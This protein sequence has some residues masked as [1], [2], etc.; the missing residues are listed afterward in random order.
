MGERWS[1][2]ARS[3]AYLL[4]ARLVSETAWLL[5]GGVDPHRDLPRWLPHEAF[6]ALAALFLTWVF[7]RTEGRGLSSI[8]LGWSLAWWGLFLRGLLTGALIIL[9]SALAAT[10]G[11]VRWSLGGLD[12]GGFLAGA[13]LYLAV[14]LLEELQFRGYPFQRLVQGLGSWPGQLLFAAYF[15][16]AHW[17]NPGM[18]GSTR[19]WATLNIGLAALLF[20]YSWLRSG[21]L[22]PAL[23]MHFAWNLVQG[24]LL[25]FGVSGTAGLGF[26]QP[27]A[28]EGKAWMHGGSFGLEAALPCALACVLAFWIL[29]RALPPARMESREEP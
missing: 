2:I 18:S 7:L 15:A 19:V 9:A 21:S 6:G 22:A 13:W 26:L 27:S 14:S 4:A 5:H 29:H 11:G 8:G 24:P 17:G 23:G 20:G 25:G 16:W 28:P 3:A 1:L 10:L 12:G